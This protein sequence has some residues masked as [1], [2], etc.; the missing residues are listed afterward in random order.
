MS[1][2]TA[3]IATYW[4]LGFGAVNATLYSVWWLRT[5]D[6]RRFLRGIRTKD[7]DPI[8]AAWWL[9]ASWEGASPQQERYA[10][11]VAVS[12]LIMGEDAE[13]DDDGR[14]TVPLGRLGSQK[15]PVLA[16][17]VT[18]LRRHKGATVYE[19]LNA[20]PFQRFR[21]ALEAR[22]AP[23]RTWFGYYRVPAL[24]AAFVTAFGMS[25]HA[26]LMRC[27]VPG[28]PDRD[29]GYWTTAWIPV[30]AALAALAALWPQE[31]SRPWRRFTRRCRAAVTGALA[32]RSSQTRYRVY[33]ST[34]A[35]SDRR[36]P[37]D[38]ALSR[39]RATADITARKPSP[40]EGLAEDLDV[41]LATG[42]DAHHDTAGGGDMGGGD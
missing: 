5:R 12:L 36:A 11:E 26:M 31:L 30:W 16:A 17:L 8:Q 25:M 24:T 29:P 10:A 3:R 6:E 39:P 9:G 23:L 7:V 41:D 42:S 38:K 21:T 35:P 28:L 22:R 19:L 20:P 33:V 32:D 27:A 1:G 13:I 2:E 15:D 40:Y 14:I 37:E 4:L 18:L 34:S